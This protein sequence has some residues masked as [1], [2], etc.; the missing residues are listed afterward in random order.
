[1]DHERR[2]CSAEK[3]VYTIHISFK[4]MFTCCFDEAQVLESCRDLMRQVW[5][6]GIQGCKGSQRRGVHILALEQL[7][8]AQLL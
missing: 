8:D 6:H 2:I 1:M 3:K 7:E 4:K 5:R